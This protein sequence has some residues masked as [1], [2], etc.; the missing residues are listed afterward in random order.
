MSRTTELSIIEEHRTSSWLSLTTF[1]MVINAY[2]DG[3]WTQL[4]SS[5]VACCEWR[6]ENLMRAYRGPMRHAHT[7]PLH[8]RVQGGVYFFSQRCLEL[9]VHISLFLSQSGSWEFL[10]VVA[11]E[12]TWVWSVSF[13]LKL[14]SWLLLIS[15]MKFSGADHTTSLMSVLQRFRKF[16]CM[17][18]NGALPALSFSGTIISVSRPIPNPHPPLYS[19]YLTFNSIC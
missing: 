13:R 17:R 3:T 5:H 8:L 6:L 10:V 15:S 12:K 2:G 18:V 9:F 19:L 7:R 11:K 4:G 1:L 16:I 14:S